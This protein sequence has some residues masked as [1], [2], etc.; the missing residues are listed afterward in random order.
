M[1]GEAAYLP[2]AR[3]PRRSVWARRL[4]TNQGQGNTTWSATFARAEVDQGNRGRR[5]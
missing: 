2:R 5:G 3:T 1:F 4:R